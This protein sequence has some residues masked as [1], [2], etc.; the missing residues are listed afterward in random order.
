MKDKL[1]PFPFLHLYKGPIK[2]LKLNL[3]PKSNFITR[4]GTNF[5]KTLSS[6]PQPHL[7]FLFHRSPKGK[8]RVFEQP[9]SKFQYTVQFH[10]VD[11]IIINV[12]HRIS[13][14]PLL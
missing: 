8:L 5:L 1:Y 2:S 12:I 10:S 11:E 7:V 6:L 13:V 14:L 3:Y 9:L 4:F